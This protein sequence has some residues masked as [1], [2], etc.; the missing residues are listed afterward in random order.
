VPIE[1]TLERGAVAIADFAQHPT[2][3]FVN[4]VMLVVEQ[5]LGES[6]RVG[7]RALP[8]ERQRG[9]DRDTA[10]PEIVGAREAVQRSPIALCEI[11]ADDCRR[12]RVDEIPVLRFARVV[13]PPS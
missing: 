2:R 4:E 5:E 11:A 12:R 7:E 9:Q 10:L 8:D 13:S 3:R 6:E 1:K